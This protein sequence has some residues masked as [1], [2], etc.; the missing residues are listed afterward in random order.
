MSH[1]AVVGAGIGGLSV[2][3]ALR[4]AGHDVTVHEQARAFGRVGADIN[5]TPNAVNAL[6]G[7]GVGAEIRAA[8]ARPTHRISRTWDSGEETS[9]LAMADTAQ[10]RYGAPQLTMHR[11]D[12]MTALEHAAGD[13]IRFGSRVHGLHADHTGVELEFAE[14]GTAR[15]DAAIGADGIHSA[16]R[17][18]LFGPE[19]PQFTG[20]VAY[21]SVVPVT[22]LAGVPDVGA[23]TKWW[24]PDPDTQIVTFPLGHGNVFVFATTPRSTWTEESWTLPGDP[25]ELRSHYTDFHPHARALLDAC[26]EVLASAL[27]VRDPL[28]R[29]GTGSATLLGDAC[30]PMTPFMAQG[31]G[32][33]IE[34]A[35]VLARCVE[36][37][38]GLGDAFAAYEH[39]RQERTARI[40]I[41]SRGNNWLK[42]AGNGDWVYEYN[43]WTAPLAGP[44]VA[45]PA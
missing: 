34:D 40:Q 25:D 29:W 35:V 24:G 6:D 37:Y 33:S 36:A 10:D 27:Y 15:A 21:R 2:A 3:I 1:F 19:Q 5:L 17:S 12:L 22:R 26:E 30:H 16:V 31:A 20:V 9:R 39:S 44:Q 41:G 11:A 7:L 4:K 8:A 13:V 14:G 32:Q 43:P 23:F 38:S 42:D 28:P 45:S 18:A